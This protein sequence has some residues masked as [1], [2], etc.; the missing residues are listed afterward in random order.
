VNFNSITQA[1]GDSSV[2]RLALRQQLRRGVYYALLC[3]P[4][5]YLLAFMLLVCARMLVPA[6]TN[7]SLGVVLQIVLLSVFGLT[8]LLL[9]ASVHDPLGAS[10]RTGVMDQ[11]LITGLSPQ[12]WLAG[13][14]GA[15]LFDLAVLLALLWPF[16]LVNVLL[17][18]I[19]W[20][21]TVLSLAIVGA[22]VLTFWF[23]RLMVWRSLL[24]TVVVAITVVA[25]F[26]F[27]WVLLFSDSSPSGMH[28]GPASF[29]AAASPVIP[30]FKLFAIECPN[31]AKLAESGC[32]VVGV[33]LN[34]T[35]AFFLA[36]GII[37]TVQIGYIVLGTRRAVLPRT[38][39]RPRTTAK[40]PKEKAPV[41]KDPG[42][43]PAAAAVSGVGN[44]MEPTKTNTSATDIRA[45][46][47][48]ETG[49]GSQQFYYICRL[50]QENAVRSVLRYEDMFC[51]AWTVLVVCGLLTAAAYGTTAAL[52]D[53]ESRGNAAVVF[54]F[55]LLSGA[56]FAGSGLCMPRRLLLGGGLSRLRRPPVFWPILATVAGALILMVLG[57]YMG[58][59]A[60]SPPDTGP[61]G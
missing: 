14:T 43:A 48:T 1:I 36:T 38:A 10:Q 26:V 3:C 41:G 47:R 23:C 60:C 42:T 32:I 46:K 22:T 18:D 54:A 34:H 40:K 11:F 13:C 56:A 30:L 28:L 45:R 50:F 2:F 31:L 4:L 61:P 27:S 44:D 59:V 37:W 5:I 51:S 24:P 57:L 16:A 52:R 49:V 6:T 9:A 33:K 25:Q 39:E 55:V 20:Y 53:A 58:G 19:S 17:G 7:L 21:S 15:Y 12:E 29:L 35:V 8:A